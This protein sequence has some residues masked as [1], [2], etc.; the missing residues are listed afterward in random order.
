M[1]CSNMRSADET[2]AERNRPLEGDVGA[3]G[4]TKATLKSCERGTPSC[5]TNLLYRR[6]RISEKAIS[7]GTRSIMMEVLCAA[8]IEREP[9]DTDELVVIVFMVETVYA[10]DTVDIVGEGGEL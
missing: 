4:R 9:G 3:L 7:L 8:L 10:D 1:N 2:E 5:P 6:S